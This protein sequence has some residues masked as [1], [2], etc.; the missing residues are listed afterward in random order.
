MSA[1]GKCVERRTLCGR[2][3][4]EPNN[5]G[6][7][8]LAGL[9]LLAAWTP[10]RAQSSFSQ[11]AVTMGQAVFPLDMSV[12]R[13]IPMTTR[14]AIQ[15]VSVA[16]PSVADVVVITERELVLN[17][18]DSGDTDL[19]IWLQDGTKV[20]YR[21][22]VHSPTDRKQ[23]LLE[24][25]IAEAD[26]DLL[27]ELG[28]SFLWSDQH[29][30]AGTGNFAT[31]DPNPDGTVPIRD[32]GQFATILS[33]GEIDNLIGMLELQETS[34]RFR[35]L[36]E[37]NL[38]AANGEE[39]EFLA[40]GEIPIPVAQTTASG[41]IPTVTIDWREFGIKLN[42]TPEILSEELVKLKIEPEVSNLDFANAVTIAGFA[43]PALRTR[44][45]TTTLDLRE[46]QTLAIAGLLS[47]Q[48]EKVVTGLPLLKDI[49]ILGLLFSS[50][51]Y[52]RNETELLVLVT[53][54]V[55]DP[56]QAPPPPPM[57]GE[58]AGE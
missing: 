35:I 3:L 30:R 57:P 29:S 27:R 33:V 39:A 12:G 28:F 25:R 13:S 58:G 46:G 22:S 19:L 47:S 48:T 5:R 41:G 49:P 16:N 14:T 45:A 38:V 31:R 18:L 8:L 54:H 10:L 26:R 55:V 17:A 7:W 37:P 42:F 53:P 20:H 32:T 24:V 2:L 9:A 50:Q 1:K 11:Q 52:Q 15:R 4:R 44:R 56:M 34:G 43:V 6:V 40:G 21:V 36:A 23:V 51:R